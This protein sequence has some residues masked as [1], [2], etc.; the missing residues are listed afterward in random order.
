MTT[1][2]RGRIPAALCL[3]VE[4]IVAP[5]ADDAALWMAEILAA[6]RLTGSF[7]VMGELA[8][9]WEARGRRDVVEALKRHDLGFHSTW[10]SVHPTTTEICL[11]RDFRDGMDALWEWDS[12][13]W[14]AA[15]RVLGRPLVGW[16]RTGSSWAPSVMGVMGRMGRAYAYSPVRLPGH[17]VCW[18]AGCLGFCDDGVGGFDQSLAD[19]ALF[20]RRLAE[21]DA[22]IEARARQERRGAEWLCLFLGHPTRVVHEAFWD[23]VNFAYGANPPRAEWRPAPLH[24][25]SRVPTM[26]RNYARLCAWLSRDERLEIVP[27]SALVRRFDGQRPF[28]AHAELL[29]AAR[30]AAERG[31]VLFTEH[32]SAAELLLMF[33]EA[34]ARPAAAYARPFAYGPLRRPPASARTRFAQP[35]L[36]GAAAELLRAA[37]DG[38]LP[39]SVAIEGQAVGIGT[40]FVALAGLLVGHPEPATPA[41]APWPPEAEAVADTVARMIPGWV[42]HPRSMDLSGLLEQTRLQCWTLKPACPRE[43]A[44]TWP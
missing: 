36:Q 3:D 10:H 44:P 30:A 42:I 7:M 11:D 12:E 29:E 24:D 1:S 39:P 2:G 35:A 19:D 8:R 43:E 38:W 34:A 14:E 33:A 22:A 9:L 5:E 23:A 13:G 21:A 16:G 28:A 37:S 18:Y 15:E 32:F 25:P 40:L 27:W 26:R 17:N 6:H 20:E 4:D 41:D 31:A